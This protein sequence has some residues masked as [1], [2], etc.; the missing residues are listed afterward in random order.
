LSVELVNAIVIEG[1]VPPLNGF[2]IGSFATCVTPTPLE[3]P[4]FRKLPTQFAEMFGMATPRVDWQLL[5]PLFPFGSQKSPVPLL[6]RMMFENWFVTVVP[7]V[8]V[9]PAVR[10]GDANV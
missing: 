9:V 1:S 2:P 4:V 6:L 10:A 7:V 3:P 8:D 5:P